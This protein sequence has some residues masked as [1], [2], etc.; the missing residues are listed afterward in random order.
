MNI[1]FNASTLCFFLFMVFLYA[2]NRYVKYAKEI[3]ESSSIAPLMFNIGGIAALAF[4]TLYGIHT[5]WWAPFVLF[6]S[7]FILGFLYLIITKIIPE[8]VFSL[9]AYIAIPVCGF[10][11]FYLMP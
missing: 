2:Q 3:G 8:G 4:L 9:L 11:M 7:I 5:V 1:L 10:F 6:G